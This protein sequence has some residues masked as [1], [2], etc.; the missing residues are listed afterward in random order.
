MSSFIQHSDQNLSARSVEGVGAYRED[1]LI[2]EAEAL[3]GQ[4]LLDPWH[5]THL[6]VTLR[7][8]GIA[9][10][11]DMNAVSAFLLRGVA[12]AVGSAEYASQRLA[13]LRDGYQADAHADGEA[14]VAP[15]ET[16]ALQHLPQG[17]GDALG[18]GDAA[19]LE[20]DTEFVASQ[21]GK[22]IPLAQ[23]GA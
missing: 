6:A 17:I 3:I 1:R 15:A 14:L 4:R 22:G 8:H 11:I 23:L 13:R 21:P 19:M 9:G 18:F 2:V 16:E 7:E 10:L 20:Q 12:G 5:P